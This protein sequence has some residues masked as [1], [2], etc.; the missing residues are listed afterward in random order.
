MKPQTQCQFSNNNTYLETT[1]RHSLRHV[2]QGT[3]SDEADDLKS[4][5]GAPASERRD[6]TGGG[7]PADVVVRE[8]CSKIA[9]SD[10]ERG[11]TSAPNSIRRPKFN[12]GAYTVNPTLACAGRSRLTFTGVGGYHTT[13]RDLAH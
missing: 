9:L 4:K 7:N 1:P 12:I 10:I 13:W 8:V 3:N 11:I 5:Q 6:E 2:I